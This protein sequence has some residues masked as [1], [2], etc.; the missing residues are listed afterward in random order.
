MVSNGFSVRKTRWSA[1]DF[2]TGAVS[3][4]LYNIFKTR[5]K[6]RGKG[7]QQ[8]FFGP[9]NDVDATQKGHG[10][11]RP[12]IYFINLRILNSNENESLQKINFLDKLPSGLQIANAVCTQMFKIAGWYKQK[13]NFDPTWNFLKVDAQMYNIFNLAKNVSLSRIKWFYFNSQ[14]IKKT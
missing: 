9:V 7:G 1:I 3:K 8:W 2:R 6:W 4:F 12:K 14:T 11:F 13:D 10:N 5:V